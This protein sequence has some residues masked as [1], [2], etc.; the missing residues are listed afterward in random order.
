MCEYILEHFYSYEYEVKLVPEITG[1]GAHWGGS[2]LNIIGNGT[3]DKIF[4]HTGLVYHQDTESGIY[5]ET[6]S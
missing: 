2:C 3:E 6:E 4:I 1:Y 5:L